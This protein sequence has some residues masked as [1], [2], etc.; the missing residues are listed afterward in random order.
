M[1]TYDDEGPRPNITLI[2]NTF[3]RTGMDGRTEFGY[4]FRRLGDN[5]PVEFEIV[6]GAVSDLASAAA[7]IAHYRERMEQYK[8]VAEAIVDASRGRK[9]P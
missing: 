7:S 3:T 8:W 2:D 5:Q 4:A 6:A 1:I 9:L